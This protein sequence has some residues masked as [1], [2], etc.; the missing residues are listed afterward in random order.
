MSKHRNDIYGDI[1]KDKEN[2]GGE[3][4]IPAATVLLLKDTESGPEVLML[5]KTSKIAFGGMWVFPGGKIDQA[6]YGDPDD[7]DSAARTAAARET[8]EEAGIV[9]PE[10]TLVELDAAASDLGFPTL[11][12]FAHG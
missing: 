3:P 12:D 2:E 4:A 9:I 5:H 1:R 6:D 7:H 11:S 10:D 8:H